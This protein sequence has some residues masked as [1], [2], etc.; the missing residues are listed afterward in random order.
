MNS[1]KTNK[2][3]QKATSSYSPAVRIVCWTM[4]ILL[5]ISLIATSIVYFVA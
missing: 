1:N 4:A 5:G 3:S 2:N